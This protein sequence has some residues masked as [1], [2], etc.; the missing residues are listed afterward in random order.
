MP[1]SPATSLLKIQSGGAPGTSE[2]GLTPP[3]GD[4]L[5]VGNLTTAQ[6][7]QGNVNFIMGELS[8]A[9]GNFSGI[10]LPFKK[11]H[12]FDGFG[13]SFPVPARLSEVYYS[14]CILISPNQ[15]KLHAN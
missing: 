5:R 14:H 4:K 15:M 10:Y 7:T 3:Q 11:I 2:E 6:G 13:E 1:E 8:W 12:Y 9:A